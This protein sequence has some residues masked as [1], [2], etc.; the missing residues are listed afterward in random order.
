MTSRIR[1]FFISCLLQYKALFTWATPQAYVMSKIL[2]PIFQLIFFVQLGI[3]AAGRVN[4]AYFAVGNALQLTALN[5]VF[6]VIMT[7]GNERSFGTLPLLLPSPANRLATFSGP[8]F[9]HLVDG[10]SSVILGFVVVL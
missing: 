10:I 9:I 6:G 7:V 2:V 4:V 1:L 8:L 5:G 3:F